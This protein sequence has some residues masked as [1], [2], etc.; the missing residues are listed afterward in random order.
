M[1][2][3][4]TTT[5]GAE[6]VG[7]QAGGGEDIAAGA[8]ALRQLRPYQR[9]GVRGL[10]DGGAGQLR[11]SCGTGK[12]LMY[13]RI[14]EQVAPGPALIVVATP[15]VALVDQILRDWRGD[16]VVDFAALAVCSDDTL[17]DAPV[18]L[19]DL[20]AGVTTDPGDVADWI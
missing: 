16:A 7:P 14:A 17:I 15:T 10:R 11:L 12:T 8:P 5:V 3:V 20:T 13:L 19:E 4:A 1:P 6:L 18:H 9:D 2:A